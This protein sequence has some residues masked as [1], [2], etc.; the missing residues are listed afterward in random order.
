MTKAVYAA[1]AAVMLVSPAL[2]AQPAGSGQRAGAGAGAG[3]GTGTAAGQHSPQGTAGAG[4]GGAGAAGG[5]TA[6]AG[7]TG[8]AAADAGASVAQLQQL[9]QAQKYNDVIREAQRILRLRPDALAN[10]DKGQV[11]MLKG[12]AHLALKQQG[13][14]TQAFQ[15][16]AKESKDPDQ[17]SLAQATVTLIKKS[18]G[19]VYR[20]K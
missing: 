12:E 6:G 16:A 4:A 7:A 5:A 18:P 14:A 2:F 15:E 9:M 20:P 11:Q 8:G 1:A 3:T 10:V 19:L 13:P 17:A